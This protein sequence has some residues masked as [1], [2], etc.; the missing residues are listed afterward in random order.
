MLCNLAAYLCFKFG[1]F[2]NHT[3]TDILVSLSS[4]FSETRRKFKSLSRWQQ[5][6]WIFNVLV[7]F[8]SFLA[9]LAIYIP[10][11]RFWP[12]GF[13]TLSI[14]VVLVTHIFLTIYWIWVHSRRAWA[15]IV[16]L[17]LALPFFQRTFV[18]H[19]SRP[20]TDQKKI[21]VLSFNTQRLNAHDYY[22]GNRTKPK[23]IIEWIRD[24]DADIK[25]L[26]EFH[27]E[28]GSRVFNAITKIATH[29]DYNYYITPL[30]QLDGSKG[31]DGVAI[32]SKF[33][34]INTGD[35]VF[36]RRT[37]N[38]AIFI[39]VKVGEDTLRIFSVHLYSMSIRAK[40]L[41]SSISSTKK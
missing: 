20:A 30:D 38:K 41:E 13:L 5:I 18:L 6:L 15:S 19:W 14:P 26:Q 32:F 2:S 39:D 27:D 40:N 25:C 31:F 8:Y 7:Y 10:P 37:L 23:K 21:K 28:D 16:I 33:P 22:G 17:L 11:A 35:I 29:G 3:T 34:I 36:D 24:S 12:V 4:F 1:F 9:F